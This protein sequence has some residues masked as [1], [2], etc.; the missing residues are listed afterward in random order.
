MRWLAF[1]VALLV[2][3]T[4]ALAQSPVNVTADEL[5]LEQERSMAVFTGNVVVKRDDL[6]LWADRVEVQYGSGGVQEIKELVATGKVRLKT[7]DQDATSSRA[8][9][10]P[11]TQILRMTGNVVV[12]NAAGT[13]EGPELIV[14]LAAQTTTFPASGQR[15]T[16]VFT[17]E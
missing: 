12:V 10:N 5:A 11:S 16:G 3:A 9:Y 6:T 14:N 17:P 2:L 8:T 1:I 15:I 4:P 7:R 13:V